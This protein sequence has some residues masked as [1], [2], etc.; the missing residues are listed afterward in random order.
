MINWPAH[1]CTC[2]PCR[3]FI[4]FNIVRLSLNFFEN[5]FRY[6]CC[7]RLN[8]CSFCSTS[9]GAFSPYV[10]STS[11]HTCNKCN[12]GLIMLCCAS[13][14]RWIGRRVFFFSVFS[15]RKSWVGFNVLSVMPIFLL[16]NSSILFYLFCFLLPWV[17]FIYLFRP[18]ISIYIFYVR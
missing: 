13:S 14:C 18:G 3:L 2:S 5:S 4:C 10:N 12:D 11:T 8:L 9:N 15:V 7:L 17:S 6:F 1:G 16:L